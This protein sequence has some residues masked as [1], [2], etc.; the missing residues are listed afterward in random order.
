MQSGLRGCGHG[1]GG[2]GYGMGSWVGREI[3]NAGTCPQKEDLL[4][5]KIRSNHWYNM[6]VPIYS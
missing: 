4:Q 5:S 1:A 2:M 6:H 3:G